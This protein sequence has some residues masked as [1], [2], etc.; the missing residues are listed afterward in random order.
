MKRGNGCAAALALVLIACA[1]GW[2]WVTSGK[3]TFEDRAN[4]RLATGLVPRRI[5]G[6]ARLV[7][8]DFQA[9]ADVV[10]SELMFLTALVVPSYAFGDFRTLA[11]AWDGLLDGALHGTG[12]VHGMK[13]ELGVFAD[14]LTWRRDPRDAARLLRL[15]RRCGDLHLRVL[16]ESSAS[17]LLCDLFTSRELDREIAQECLA[18]MTAPAFH[19]TRSN[20]LRE[21]RDKM[22]AQTLLRAQK[23]PGTIRPRSLRNKWRRYRRV[24]GVLDEIDEI[25]PHLDRADGLRR[26]GEL[27]AD[28]PTRVNLEFVV[29]MICELE[30]DARFRRRLLRLSLGETA[31]LPIDLWTGQRIDAK[32]WDWWLRHK[33]R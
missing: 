29:Q 18:I 15:A 21:Y 24:M 16:V 8:P 5:H 20:T 23:R 9:P 2:M 13:L 33:P 30:R 4:E 10:P 19:P 22:I 3:R 1:W 7:P 31:P 28:Q 26:Y 25:L 12:R 14:R 6:V 32:W 27:N 11:H 17:K